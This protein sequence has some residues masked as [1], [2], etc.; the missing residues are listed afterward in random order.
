[1]FGFRQGLC[2]L[3]AMVDHSLQGG[4]VFVTKANDLWLRDAHREVIVAVANG[5]LISILTGTVCQSHVAA[6][7]PLP[8]ILVMMLPVELAKQRLLKLS[9]RRLLLLLPRTFAL[10]H[11]NN[12]V[13]KRNQGRGYTSL[14]PY[15][16]Y[17]TTF[18]KSYMIQFAPS[19]L[20][21]LLQG[22]SGTILMIDVSEI[23]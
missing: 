9:G 14:H 10:S 1:M 19:I 13:L 18:S 8:V 4:Y 23:Q 5:I 15:M 20:L 3:V 12:P 22:P 21:F 7:T 17:P 11:L 2:L 16:L 6:N